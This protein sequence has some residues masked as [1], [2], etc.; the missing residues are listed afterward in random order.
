MVGR[1]RNSSFLL[2]AARLTAGAC[3]GRDVTVPGSAVRVDL[4]RQGQGLTNNS[5]A[6]PDPI[7]QGDSRDRPAAVRSYLETGGC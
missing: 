3:Q 4:V 1:L 2:L 7:D 6:L 5:R